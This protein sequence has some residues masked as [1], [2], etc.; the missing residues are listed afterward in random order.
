MNGQENVKNGGRENRMNEKPNEK[1]EIRKRREQMNNKRTTSEWEK[2][3][4]ETRTMLRKER[5]LTCG[6]GKKGRKEG[7]ERN[8]KEE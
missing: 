4:E 5:K 1:Q 7:G 3:N 6:R 2:R 8:N